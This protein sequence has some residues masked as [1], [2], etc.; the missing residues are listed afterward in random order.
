MAKNTI[1]SFGLVSIEV[2][3]DGAVK[4]AATE[5]K[6]DSA[7]PNGNPVSQVYIEKDSDGAE[8][9][10][11]DE[12]QKGKFVGDE[13]RPVDPEKIEEIK[14][15][16]KL[17]NIELNFMPQKDVD[18]TTVS[19]KQYVTAKTGYEN[20]LRLLIE[21]M[22]K[23]KTVFVGK[24]VPVSRQA[25]MVGVV[26]N[27]RLVMMQIPYV[28]QVKEAPEVTGDKPSAKELVMAVKLI[29]ASMNPKYVEEAIDE[30]VKLKGEAITAVIDGKPVKK[31]K[32]KK[33]A[34]KGQTL[35]DLLEASL[36]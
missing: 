4:S 33:A 9:F 3:L 6:F 2:K 1:L 17:D 22:K 35:E 29:Q 5:P 24:W 32:V 25:L 8:Q 26:E 34:P 20:K 27:D 16:T 30:G 21:G 19:N 7:S 11:R 28:D 14:E 13:F 36:A 31:R 10:G 15:L 12:L 23:A 18:L